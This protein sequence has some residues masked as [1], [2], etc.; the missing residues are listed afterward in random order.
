LAQK[1]RV[2]ANPAMSTNTLTFLGATET[3]TGS[4]Y[5]IETSDSRVLIDCGMFQGYKSLRLRNWQPFPVDPKEINYVVLT[6]AHLDHSGYLPALVKLGFKGQVIMTQGTFELCKI[7]WADSAKIFEEDTERANRKGYT[8]HQPAETLFDISDVERALNK[9]RVVDFEK[10]IQLTKDLT[11]QFNRAGHIL[12][13][14]QVL[15]G[16]K[17]RRILFTGDLGRHE[18][19]LMLSPSDMVETDILV[20]ES[21]YGD[22]QHPPIDPEVELREILTKV[23]K[24]GGTAVVPAFAVGRTQAL[25]IHIWRLMNKGLIPAVPVFLNSPMAASVTSLY[26]AHK[27]EHRIELSEFEQMY[28]SVKIIRDVNESKA[29][30]ALEEP[31]IIIAASGMLTGGR[32]LHHVAKFGTEAN[33]AILLTGYQAG[34]TRGRQLLGGAKNVRIFQRDVPIKAEVFALNSLSAHMDA[35]EILT[36]LKASPKQPTMTYLTHGEPES[37]DRLRFR[38]SDELGWKVRA[39]TFGEKIDIDNPS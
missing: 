19:P 6:H 24:R 39:A 17:N 7:L 14:A 22:T 29:L 15:V 23:L 8:K 18:D 2:K 37:A 34:G 4:K 36:W 32:V 10:E 5:L 35:D 13:A 28:K 33:N 27:E 26:H 25:M 12:G 38:I 3:V 11:I 31:K 21:T 30:N 1:G 20:C 16:V 9:V